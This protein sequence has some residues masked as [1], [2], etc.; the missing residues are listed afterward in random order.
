LAPGP[1]VGIGIMPVQ[2]PVRRPNPDVEQDWHER[3]AA[4]S[5]AP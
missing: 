2:T 4:G 1:I 5:D 3:V